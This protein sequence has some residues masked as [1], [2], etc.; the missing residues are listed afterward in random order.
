VEEV[1]IAN[2]APAQ[3]FGGLLTE[4]DGG[5]ITT[6][7]AAN[8]DSRASA[9][10]TRNSGRGIAGRIR[11]SG[12]SGWLILALGAAA[13]I[14]LF[15]TEVSTLSRRTIGIGGCESRVNPGVCTTSGGDAHGHAL[16]L[17]ALV[18][19]VLALGAALGRSR[20]AAVAVMLCGLIA[21]GIALLGDAPDLGDKRGLDADYNQ[22]AAHTGPAFAF[23]IAGGLLALGCGIATLV[24]PE[25]R[26]RRSR[27]RRRERPARAASEAAAPPVPPPPPERRPRS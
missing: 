6:P 12:P 9:S 8:D 13:A 7:E 15:L 14:L 4:P 23:E 11:A 22:V 10:R 25:A 20:P 26:E 5:I 24:L 18:V 21:L 19:L 1:F 3:S 16:W 27:S 2:E 17:L